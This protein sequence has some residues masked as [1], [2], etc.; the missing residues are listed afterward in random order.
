MMSES[1]LKSTTDAIAEA[2]SAVRDTC[3]S[4]HFLNL[5]KKNY[6][7]LLHVITKTRF[8]KFLTYE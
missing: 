5:H 4:L 8:F 2:W 1:P 7:I 3:I 6:S